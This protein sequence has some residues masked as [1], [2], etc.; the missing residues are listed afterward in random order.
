MDLGKLFLKLTHIFSPV[1]FFRA[2]QGISGFSMKYNAGLKL[3][4]LTK[5]VSRHKS[6]APQ[7]N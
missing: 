4:K 1:L 6:E 2:K 3:V 7:C 5:A